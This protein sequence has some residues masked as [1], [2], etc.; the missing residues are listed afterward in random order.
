MDKVIGGWQLNGVVTTGSG[1]PYSVTFSPNQV[2][3]IGNRANV[4]S[5]AQATPSNRSIDQWFSPAAF[6][7]PQPFTYGTSAR[8]PLWGPGLFSWDMGIFKSITI[9]ERI[10]ST[11]RA[12]AFNATNHASFSNPA[13]NLSVPSTAGRITST[14]VAARTIQFGLRVDF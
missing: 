14:S 4:V 2:G 7:V 9:R 12:E 11:F 3:W 1:T 6:S 10:R 8:N 5:Y 13:A